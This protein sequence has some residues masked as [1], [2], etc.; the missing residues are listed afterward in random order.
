MSV[1]L[2][3]LIAF[4]ASVGISIYS[5][6]RII[7]FSKRVG[8]VDDPNSEYRKI[9][10]R[11]V[12]NIGGIAVFLSAM[13]VYFALCNFNT[14]HR[15]DKL[16]SISIILFFIGIKDDFEPISYNRRIIYEFLCAFLI[17]IIADIRILSMYGIF[18]VDD[19]PYWVS[20][21]M[22]SVFIVACINAYNMIDGIDGLLT[23]LCLVG[24]LVF[25]VIFFC[26]RDYAWALLCMCLAGSLLGF[27]RYNWQPAKI[28]MG[29]GGSMFLGTLFACLSLRLMQ[30]S[31]I[32]N[33]F[34]TVPIMPITIALGVIAIPLVDMLTVIVVRILRK[35]SPF[36]ADR[37]HIHHRLLDIGLSHWQTVLVLVFVNFLIVFFAILVQYQGALISILSTLAF[38]VVLEITMIFMHQLFL[39]KGKC[40]EI[41]F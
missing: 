12:P 22:T 1:Y 13:S 37:S 3:M 28:F 17:I 21:I 25:A 34:F 38:C 33:T 27:L 4:M 35:K 20:F 40:N 7:G 16:F 32:D 8:I 39:K 6:K 24:S 15:P 31:L 26:A 19:L 11:L 30:I 14:I 23:S 36:K 41:C 2:L 10:T 5:T 9:H 18:G 29:N